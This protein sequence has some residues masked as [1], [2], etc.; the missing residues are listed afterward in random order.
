M[1]R[2]SKEIKVWDG[3]DISI[4]RQGYIVEFGGEKYLVVSTYD[5]PSYLR[6]HLV[7][8]GFTPL[9]IPQ[10][11]AFF[12][13]DHLSGLK[14]VEHVEPKYLPGILDELKKNTIDAAQKMQSFK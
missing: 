9:K 2:S 14:V 3:F 1:N 13:K 10:M 11:V 7:P 6:Q 8:I 4:L 12:H 5:G